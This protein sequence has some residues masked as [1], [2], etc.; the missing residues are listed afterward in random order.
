MSLSDKG[1]LV[2]ASPDNA[3]VMGTSAINDGEWHDITVAHY[4]ALQR[5]L[6]FVDGKLVRELDGERFSPL[7]FVLG[8]RASTGGVSPLGVVDY[9]DWMVWRSALNADEV[10]YMYSERAVFHASLE[11]YAPLSLS[12]PYANLAQSMSEFVVFNRPEPKL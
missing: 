9:Q 3:V 11:L 2:Y 4:W 6:L 10:E 1:E 7:E 12:D 5:T 8:G